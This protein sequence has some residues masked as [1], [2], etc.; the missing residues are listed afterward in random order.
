MSQPENE[1]TT[2]KTQLNNNL[3]RKKKVVQKSIIQGLNFLTLLKENI[4][5]AMSQF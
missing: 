1:T 5:K 3:V 2:T 4:Q